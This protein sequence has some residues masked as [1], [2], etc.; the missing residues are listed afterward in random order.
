MTK[1]KRKH[2]GV[3]HQREVDSHV[4]SNHKAATNKKRKK[5]SKSS[6]PALKTKASAS[7][8]SLPAEIRNMIYVLVLDQGPND[9]MSIIRTGKYVKHRAGLLGVNRQINNETR[10]I[11]IRDSINLK[12]GGRE[13]A[14][15]KSAWLLRDAAK[16]LELFR[17]DYWPEKS[18]RDDEVAKSIYYITEPLLKAIGEARGVFDAAL[19]VVQFRLVSFK[20]KSQN[21]KS[22]CIR[23]GAYL[24]LFATELARREVA[25][26]RYLEKKLAVHPR[27]SKRIMDHEAKARRQG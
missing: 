2:T 25:I 12:K 18:L 14:L 26:Q 17:L 6:H 16:P 1:F 13:T 27:R 23:P 10:S 9:M 21:Y 22:C 11:T 5:E 24:D 20:P 19:E 7:F 15:A 3:S 8:L 4:D